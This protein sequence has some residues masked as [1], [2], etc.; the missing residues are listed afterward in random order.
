MLQ[1][2][3][4][5]SVV[6][7]QQPHVDEDSGTN[8]QRIELASVSSGD[9]RFTILGSKDLPLV[10][11][12]LEAG[13]SMCAEPGRMIQLPEGVKFHTVMGDG[14]EAGIMATM[15]RAAKR[16]FSGESVILA[17]FTNETDEPQLL[18][19]GTVVPGNIVPIN[20]ADYGGEIIGMHGVYLCG[21]DCLTVEMCFQQRLG[22]M[23]FGGE[24]WIL[25][26][27][28]GDG[29]VL[30]QGGGVVLKEELTPERPSIQV[31]SGC[32]VA[33]TKNLDYNVAAAPGG[34]K[35]WL[36]GGEGIFFATVT[37]PPGHKQGTVWIE[38]FPFS[39]WVARIKS[40]YSH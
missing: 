20:L 40:A 26:R 38:S 31:D 5:G 17:R 13:C 16:M 11:A 25:Q 18:R 7:Y 12:V 1:R 36:F 32:L 37:L 35:S 15:G 39:N 28:K 19:F 33:F 21:S 4:T 34:L 3:K 27:I 29:V 22:A 6:Q 8:A 30:L 10:E 23:F 14:S 24:S 9:L 2:S